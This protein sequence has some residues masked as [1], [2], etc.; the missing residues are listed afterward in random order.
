MLIDYCPICKEKFPDFKIKT[1]ENHDN[2][3]HPDYVTYQTGIKREDFFD[4]EDLK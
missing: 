3:Y 1:R 2:K 4:K